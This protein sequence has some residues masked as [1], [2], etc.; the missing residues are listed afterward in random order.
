[1]ISLVEFENQWLDEIEADSPSSTAKGHRF[2][3]KILRDWLELDTEMA[4]IIYC[5]GSGDGGID[6]AIFIPHDTD[7]GAEGDTWMLVQSK[8]GSAFRGTDTLFIEAQKVF[9]TLEG[10]RNNLSS[11][12]ESV[13]KRIRQFISQAGEKDRLEYVVATNQRLR[14]DEYDNL[15]AIRRI[16]HEKFGE[17]FRVADVSIET[18]F[19]KR[20]EGETSTGKQLKVPLKT[21]IASSGDI[22]YVGATKLADIFAF[23]QAY[24]KISGDLDMLYDKNVRKFLG[25]RR[26]V[27]KGIEY[28]IENYPERFGLYNNG[29]TIVAEAV[30]PD[31]DGEIILANPYVVNGC[32]TTRSIFL[33]LQQKLNS[34]GKGCATQAHQQWLSRLEDAVVVTKIVVVGDEGEGLLTETT[35]YTNSQNAVSD[36]DFLSLETNFRNWASLFNIQYGIFLEIQRGAW[37][38]RKAWQKQN[39]LA[40]PQYHESAYAFDLLKIYAAGWLS[41]PGS[42]LGSNSPFS[43]GGVWFKKICNLPEF[44]IDALHAAYRLQKLAD[45]YHFGRSSEKQS[46]ALTRFLFYM[47]V[48]DLLRNFLIMHDM[49]HDSISISRA[50]TKLDA[51]NLLAEIGNTS[52]TLIDDYFR[53]SGDDSIFD[54]PGFKKTQEFRVFLMSEKLGKDD[55]YSP[56]LKAQIN[57]ARRD[58]RRNPQSDR[59]KA[60]LL[61]DN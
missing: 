14:H 34:G 2:A 36:K 26:K 35:R 6:A 1:M 31:P 37:D 13:V 55:Q 22:L 16:G 58:F 15:E 17:I 23:M 46:R 48:V 39:P 7:D 49:D 59:I 53:R 8:Y 54:E 61:E 9:A 24:K 11:L 56:G 19:N 32:Q 12:S 21:T 33:V 20:P 42:A 28:T 4:E 43:P 29:I 10:A 57:Y 30:E 27:N 60:L 40:K 38:A 25:H 45:N 3:Q 52:I 5:D 18:V 44:G 50:I 41:E 51:N 47:I